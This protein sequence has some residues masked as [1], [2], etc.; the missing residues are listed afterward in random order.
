MARPAPHAVGGQQTHSHASFCYEKTKAEARVD[1]FETKH[2]QRTLAV[3]LHTAYFF[4][5]CV[6]KAHFARYAADG[7]SWGN[8]SNAPHGGRVTPFLLGAEGSLNVHS[9]VADFLVSSLRD[10]T[11]V[12]HGQLV[13][14]KV[15]FPVCDSLS[16]PNCPHLQFPLLFPEGPSVSTTV[17]RGFGGGGGGSSQAPAAYA[18]H[19]HRP[20][21]G[22]AGGSR[23]GPLRSGVEGAG[24]A[25]KGAPRSLLAPVFLP[26]DSSMTFLPLGVRSSSA[27]VLHHRM[28]RPYI[29]RGQYIE[30]GVGDVSAQ[31]LSD[32]ISNAIGHLGA[33]TGGTRDIWGSPGFPSSSSLVCF[34]TGESRSRKDCHDLAVFSSLPQKY[35]AEVAAYH[36][37]WNGSSHL[38]LFNK[39]RAPFVSPYLE[40]NYG[41]GLP[42]V[43]TRWRGRWEVKATSEGANGAEGRSLHSPRH[44]FNAFSLPLTGPVAEGFSARPSSYRHLLNYRG[45]PEAITT[46]AELV[47]AEGSLSHANLFVPFGIWVTATPRRP[48]PSCGE[49]DLEASRR[50]VLLVRGIQ[51][52]EVMFSAEVP[53]SDIPEVHGE[54]P[55]EV[56]KEYRF[57]NALDFIKSATPLRRVDVLRFSYGM[58][59]VSGS[60][61]EP[62]GVQRPLHC[63]PY[64][65]ALGAVHLLVAEKALS[66]RVF[67]AVDAATAE[68]KALQ[69]KAHAVLSHRK[70]QEA[71]KEALAEARGPLLKQLLGGP[72]PKP[73]RAHMPSSSPAPTTRADEFSGNETEDQRESGVFM[74]VVLWAQGD[75]ER[76]LLE[77]SDV[78]STS[79]PLNWQENQRIKFGR[80]DSMP[81]QFADLRRPLK[82]ATLFMQEI[83]AEAP[84]IALNQLPQVKQVFYRKPALE[85]HGHFKNPDL[86]SSGMGDLRSLMKTI[87]NSLSAS[88]SSSAKEAAS[89]QTEGFSVEVPA[90]AKTPTAGILAAPS[91]GAAANKRVGRSSKDETKSSE[92][93]ASSWGKSIVALTE[94]LAKTSPGFQNI[95]EKMSE[96]IAAASEKAYLEGAPKPGTSAS[97]GEDLQETGGGGAPPSPHEDEPRSPTQSSDKAPERPKKKRKGEGA[98]K[99][100]LP[101]PGTTCGH[102]QK[103][104]LVCLL[105]S[106]E[107][108]LEGGSRAAWGWGCQGE[109]KAGVGWSTHGEKGRAFAGIPEAFSR[110][111]QQLGLPIDAHAA[112]SLREALSKLGGF[113]SEDEGGGGGRQQAFLPQQEASQ[114]IPT[115]PPKAPQEGLSSEKS[116]VH[117]A[118]DPDKGGHDVG[119]LASKSRDGE[120]LFERAMQFMQ[121]ADSSVVSA[122]MRTA[123]EHA[124]RLWGGDVHTIPPPSVLADILKS[125]PVE[126][127]EGPQEKDKDEL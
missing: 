101:Q 45:P 109:E 108:F 44:P 88:K 33:L 121:E 51:E 61:V 42:D 35:T 30:D 125:L 2:M 122:L 63:A 91:A 22:D 7:C 72:L 86:D 55:P 64:Q 16:G 32:A 96:H 19:L 78:S 15:V 104:L 81:Y 62:I 99:N 41:Y 56:P 24:E 8:H 126:S 89:A 18:A 116:A 79:L 4:L 113:P 76:E 119:P 70:Q 118:S 68:G 31:S 73:W 46:F 112:E 87:L 9:C 93:R 66:N 59:G 21:V 95:I 49:E 11:Y 100:Q 52:E 106:A 40:E 53:L 94:I 6:V 124:R 50:P 105:L 17:S 97:A 120:T 23:G 80:F 103:C 82:K 10:L 1:S 111:A 75:A 48:L 92:D 57:V 47:S 67:Y 98:S 127:S 29:N 85:T 5:I 77:S 83:P 123:E 38:L 115:K 58:A 110:M 36:S 117:S 25:E 102:F 43:E 14:E 27:R 26:V 84:V 71:R 107:S 37:G 34:Y 114:S 20:L 74:G 28:N 39:S 12:A 13:P 69:E 65:A 90:K 54:G 60:G 3:P